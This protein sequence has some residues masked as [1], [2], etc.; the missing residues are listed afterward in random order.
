MK[1][2]SGVTCADIDASGLITILDPTIHAEVTN[3]IRKRDKDVAIALDVRH[4]GHRTNDGGRMEP[5]RYTEM[6]RAELDEEMCRRAESL[7]DVLAFIRSGH[8]HDE[9][10]RR[11]LRLLDLARKGEW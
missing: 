10:V 6:T 2:F 8:L 9:E 4:D 3:A 11:A 5:D 1:P 7:A